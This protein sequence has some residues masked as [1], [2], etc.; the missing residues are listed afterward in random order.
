MTFQFA[1]FTEFF[2]MGGHGPFIWLSYLFTLLVLIWLVAS[3]L[4]R[5]R[6]LWSAL[7]R[8]RPGSPQPVEEE[9]ES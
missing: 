1:S 3:P 5:E 4:I 9:S 7:A 8:R 2:A 6:R